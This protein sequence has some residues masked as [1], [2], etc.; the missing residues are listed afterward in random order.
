MKNMKYEAEL[1]AMWI[2]NLIKDSGTNGVV[3]G[4]SG[5]KDSAVVA[6][7]C[8]KAGVRLY[9]LV[10]PMGNSEEDARLAHVLGKH[11]EM[12]DLVFDIDMLDDLLGV[13][14]DV[15]HWGE[16]GIEGP[17]KVTVGNLKAR[18]R[19]T[20]L[21]SYANQ[22]NLLVAG[23]GNKSE[24]IMGYFTKW[25]DGACDFNPISDLTWTEVHKLGKELGI[26]EEIL[27]RPSSAGLWP[28]QTDEEEMGVTYQEIDRYLAGKSI[29]EESWKIIQKHI[30]R[31]QHKRRGIKT[32][33]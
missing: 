16:T 25:G 30:N 15:F 9:G 24:Y 26:P 22:H 32:Y 10:M 17:D 14:A 21:Y 18:I 19:M 23:T 6:A 12:D 3:L 2:A 31:S 29:S 7:L 20:I 27:S 1:R 33:R 8:K 4:F 5:G 28:G 13:Y 11:L